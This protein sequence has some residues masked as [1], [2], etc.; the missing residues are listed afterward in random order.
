MG[1]LCDLFVAAPGQAPQDEARMNT[2]RFIKAI[3]REET[4]ELAGPEFA[5]RGSPTGTKQFD[6]EKRRLEELS[7]ERSGG[8]NRFPRESVKQLASLD[9]GA[10]RTIGTS[11]AATEAPEGPAE[12]AQELVAGLSRLARL[13]VSAGRGPC[14]WGS[15]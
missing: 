6:G 1:I 4:K 9:P 7:S 5:A 2:A 11:W 14:P 15:L 8:L 13:A 12:A 3:E 10:I